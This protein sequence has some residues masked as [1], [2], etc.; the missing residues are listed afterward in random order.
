MKYLENYQELSECLDLLHINKEPAFG[1]PC[2]SET[3]QAFEL[4]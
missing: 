2:V 3:A 1:F 4:G